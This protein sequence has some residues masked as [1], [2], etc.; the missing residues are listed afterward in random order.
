MKVNNSSS[1]DVESMSGVPQGSILG[2]VLF[3]LYVREVEHIARQHNFS[4]HMYADDTQC[5]FGFSNDA[6]K[7]VA[8]HPIQCF[9]SDLK[10]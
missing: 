1:Y 10:S 3:S 4:I 5:Y 8:I 6:P 2:P 9:I 7:S